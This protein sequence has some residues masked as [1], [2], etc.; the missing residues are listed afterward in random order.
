VNDLP[1]ANPD[2]NITVLQAGIGARNPRQGFEST[3]NRASV[4]GLHNI[5]GN[6]PS[7]FA[8][9]DIVGRTFSAAL[10]GRA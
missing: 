9:A 1:S 4:R 10:I 5:P 3:S 6:S 8:E 2:Q 7:H